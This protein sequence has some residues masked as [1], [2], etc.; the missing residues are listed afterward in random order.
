MY[1][2][3]IGDAEFMLQSIDQRLIYDMFASAFFSVQLL[4]QELRVFNYFTCH[5]VYIVS[6]HIWVP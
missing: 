1:C 4:R 3:V 2:D 6:P 5:V